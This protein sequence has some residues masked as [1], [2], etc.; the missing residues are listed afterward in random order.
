MTADPQE[1][2]SAQLAETDTAELERRLA[3]LRDAFARIEHFPIGVAPTIAR[4]SPSSTRSAAGVPS[5]ARR[6]RAT[7]APLTRSPGPARARRITAQPAA[8][9]SG[10]LAAP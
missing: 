2:R 9:R 8:H 1:L 3:M 10:N 6:D 7:A 5:R 4:T